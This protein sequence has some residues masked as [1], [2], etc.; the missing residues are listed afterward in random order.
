[1]SYVISSYTP[2]LRALA[3]AREQA[4]HN[5]GGLSRSSRMLLVAAPEAP[6]M[7]ELKNV[8]EEVNGVS[9]ICN[10]SLSVV[11]LDN[12]APD[13]VIKQ[14]P[15]A[16]IVHIACH[17]VSNPLNPDSSH[18]VMHGGGSSTTNQA[19]Q[20]QQELNVRR[21][22]A[23]RSPAAELAYLS[24]GSAAENG[25]LSL[26]DETINIASAF[27]L[28]G[29]RHVVGTLWRTKDDVCLQVACTFYRTLLQ[30]SSATGLA[31]SGRETMKVAQA[32]HVAMDEVRL[33]QPNKPLVW[34]PFV[35]IGS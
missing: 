17:G 21:I 23:S 10:A 11:R 20:Q 6:G 35:H 9:A 7:A 34:A 4:G 13:A 18:L 14:L 32:L 8:T 25:S 1:M 31:M 12:P 5:P 2:T 27:Q 26:A 33:Q 15:L 24:T 16:N 3:Y 29:F 28:A 22:S 30:K 19:Q